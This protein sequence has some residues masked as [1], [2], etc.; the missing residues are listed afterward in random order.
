MSATRCAIS[1]TGAPGDTRLSIFPDGIGGSGDRYGVRPIITRG[2]ASHYT[3]V[4]GDG[5]DMNVSTIR[6]WSILLSAVGSI[7]NSHWHRRPGW[8]V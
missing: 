5:Q 2:P 3:I 1:D 8:V 7:I 4:V 6:V